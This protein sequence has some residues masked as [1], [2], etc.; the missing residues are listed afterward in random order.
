MRT[1]TREKL[2]QLEIDII[3]LNICYETP[4]PLEIARVMEQLAILIVR[5]LREQV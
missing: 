2:E 4:S 3:N 1:S 5:I